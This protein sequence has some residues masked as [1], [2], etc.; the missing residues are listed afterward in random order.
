MLSIVKKLVRPNLKIFLA[1]VFFSGVSALDGI[2]APYFL[3][4]F[5]NQLTS[6]QFHA[7]PRTLILWTAAVIAIY[8]FTLIYDYCFSRMKRQVNIQLK[9]AV[10]RDAYNPRNLRTDS[11]PFTAKILNDIKQIETDFVASL[12]SLIYSILQATITMYFL[13][14]TNWRI[15]LFFVVLGFIPT[16]VPRITAKWLKNGTKMW[17]GRN[18]SYTHVLNETLAARS[19]VERYQAEN[20][21]FKRVDQKLNQTENAA[22]TMS[23][24]QSISSKTVQI[25]YTLVTGI[26]LFYGAGFVIRGEITAGALITIYMAADR[27]VTPIISS[28]T[29]YNRMLSSRPLFDDLISSKQ[30]NQRESVPVFNAGQNDMVVLHNGSVGYDKPL[31]TGVEL[32]IR[33]RDKILITGPSGSGKTTLVKTLINDLPL[34]AGT[35]SLSPSLKPSPRTSMAIVEQQ[36]FLFDETILFNLTMGKFFPTNQLKQVLN[37]VGLTKYASEEGLATSVNTANRGLSGGE[38]KR[39]EIARA[40]LH[41]RDFLVVDEAFSGLDEK[42]T[43]EISNLIT[44]FPGT[45]IDIEHRVPEDISHRYSQWFDTARYLNTNGKSV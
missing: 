39:L 9:T 11:A 2:V 27:V 18:H 43:Y 31:L 40:I 22:L 5:T 14:R 36:P 35:L 25:L 17:Q 4:T 23:M 24:R 8:L 34:L 16:I 37:S 13:V 28:V 26:S 1:M 42:S 15:G 3:G 12:D 41:S 20:N 30:S 45:V 33:E 6:H 29:W 10:L 19:L 7:V 44:A 32:K 21:V 38:S